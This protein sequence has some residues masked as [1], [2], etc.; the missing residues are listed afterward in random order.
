MKFPQQNLNRGRNVPR[1][2]IHGDCAMWHPVI[3]LIVRVGPARCLVEALME[4]LMQ[5]D[6]LIGRCWR[7]KDDA[8][9]RRK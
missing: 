6:E 7:Q 2:Q 1:R 4:I 9:G 5:C 8:F 3:R